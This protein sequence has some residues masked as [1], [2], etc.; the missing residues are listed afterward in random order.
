MAWNTTPSSC[1]TFTFGEV[2]DYTIIISATSLDSFAGSGS[3]NIGE[4]INPDLWSLS[5]KTYPN[6]V[7]YELNFNFNEFKEVSEVKIFDLNGIEMHRF[8]ADHQPNTI[9]VSEF[10]NGMYIIFVD[11]E[12]GQFETKFIKQ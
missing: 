4:D 2:E 5:L 9:N 3:F 1:G 6:P 8:N 7:S 12:R 11:T 10:A